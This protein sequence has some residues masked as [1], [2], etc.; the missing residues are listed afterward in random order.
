MCVFVYVCFFLRP[1]NTHAHLNPTP[2]S[3]SSFAPLAPPPPLAPLAPLIYLGCLHCFS[4]C[5]A[6]RFSSDGTPSGTGL[7]LRGNLEADPALPGAP[8]SSS[9]TSIRRL[10][11]SDLFVTS[12]FCRSATVC[13]SV[14]IRDCIVDR[15]ACVRTSVTLSEVLHTSHAT[16][17]CSQPS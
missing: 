6:R 4:R 8:P 12:C 15:H 11:C 7:M 16:M 17:R 10:S 13:S 3:L 14:T 1:Y 9:F 5:S 2:P